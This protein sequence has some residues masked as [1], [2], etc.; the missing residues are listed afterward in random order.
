MVL[1]GLKSSGA[2]KAEEA[3]AVVAAFRGVASAS[4]A[5]ALKGKSDADLVEQFKDVPEDRLAALVSCTSFMKGVNDKNV[6]AL[7]VSGLFGNF[8]NDHS[9]II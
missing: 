5:A 2:L 8:P 7:L 6:G 1:S 3:G 9:H 4:E